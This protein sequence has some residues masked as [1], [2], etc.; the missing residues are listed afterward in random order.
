MITLSGVEFTWP[1]APRP[2]LAGVQ[3]HIP[4]GA[5]YGVVGA[6]G[7][8]KSTLLTLIAGLYA[9]N[10]G[11]LQV[12]DATAPEA[13]RPLCGLV[14]QDADAQIIGSTV[15]E[16]LLL[17]VSAHDSAT[18]GRVHALANDFDLTHLY[19]EPVQTLS[20]GQKRRLCLC[21]MLREAP[22]VLLLDEPFAGLDYPAARTLRQ[23]LA[24]NREEGLTQLVAVH[25]VEPLAD[26]ADGY[27]VL[28]GGRVQASGDAASVFGV[29]EQAGVRTPCG[30]GQGGAIQAWDGEAS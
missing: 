15:R 28:A 11:T 1:G 24:R 10:A 16:D 29:L 5:L 27:V 2:A 30:W 9:A 8:G 13:I 12:G 3:A 6:N 18:I 14:L 20:G 26:I 25:D 4:H 7:S 17:G 19:D 21:A 22:A 23:A